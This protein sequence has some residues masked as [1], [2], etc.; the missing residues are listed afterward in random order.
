MTKE[1]VPTVGKS[2]KDTSKRTLTVTEVVLDCPLGRQVRGTIRFY[3]K[4]KEWAFST[5]L[6]SWARTFR[7]KRPPA[8]IADMKVG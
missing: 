2:Y 7:D 4:R 1:L 6:E 3:R 5:P 8:P